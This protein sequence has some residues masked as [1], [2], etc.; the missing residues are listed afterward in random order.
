MSARSSQVGGPKAF[1]HPSV[2]SPKRGRD[3][4]G[5]VS[6]RNETRHEFRIG[7]DETALEKAVRE[8]VA[9]APPITPEVRDAIARLLRPGRESTS[10]RGRT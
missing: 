7:R 10:G 2:R 5:D 8:A 3:A 6:A 1:D 9:A 4:H